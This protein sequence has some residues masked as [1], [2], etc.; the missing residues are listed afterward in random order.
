MPPILGDP[1]F[2]VNS[3]A[4]VHGLSLGLWNVSPEELANWKSQAANPHLLT[5]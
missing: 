3:N 5:S 2:S 4:K 1:G